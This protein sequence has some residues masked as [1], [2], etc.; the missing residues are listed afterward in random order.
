LLKSNTAYLESRAN[1]STFKEIS[2]AVVRDLEFPIPSLEEQRRIAGVLGALDDLI[3]VNR[4]LIRD[5]DE[6][7]HSIWLDRFAG[8]VIKRDIVLS[9]LCS[10]QYG[11]TDAATSDPTGP[12]FLRVADINKNN[13]IDWNNVP[14]CAPQA[15]DGEKYKLRTGDL[16]VSRMADPGKSAMIESDIDAVFASY[17][18]RLKLHDSRLGLFIYGFLKSSYYREYSLSAM[19]G[20]VQKN[21]NAR[22]ITS[23]PLGLP[24]D[25]D[26]DAFNRL[27]KPVR[28]AMTDLLEEVGQLESTRNELLPLLLSGRV[29]VGDVAA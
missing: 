27:M 4:G 12:K 16:V 26:I 2:G 1:G 15:R 28:R 19:T 20:S 10:T 21:M 5:L 7:F 11:Y 18:V 9:D 24:D 6:L 8:F 17:L 23:A 14:H 22:V 29:R 3:E 25:A 13:W